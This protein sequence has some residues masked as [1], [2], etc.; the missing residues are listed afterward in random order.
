MFSTGVSAVSSPAKRPLTLSY[1]PSVGPARSSEDAI[2]VRVSRAVMKSLVS[3]FDAGQTPH[4]A[5]II[6]AHILLTRGRSA[7]TADCLFPDV[8]R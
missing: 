1:T 6:H 3:S 5:N 4:C 7:E 8:V 2:W